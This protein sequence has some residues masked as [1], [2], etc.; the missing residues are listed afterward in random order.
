[1]GSQLPWPF[2][3]PQLYSSGPQMV[4]AAGLGQT[5]GLLL[6]PETSQGKL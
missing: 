1:M 3:T 6:L 5:E 4:I 2:G